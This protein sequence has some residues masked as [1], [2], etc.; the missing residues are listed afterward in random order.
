[1]IRGLAFGLQSPFGRIPSLGASGQGIRV[2]ACSLNLAKQEAQQ[3]L[4]F[5]DAIP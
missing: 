5:R 2:Q 1:M 4:Q 3:W